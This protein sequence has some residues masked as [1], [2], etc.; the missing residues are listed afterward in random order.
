MEVRAQR[1]ARH[2]L[3]DPRH[4]G[5]GVGAHARRR[6]VA[7]EQL[8]ERRYNHAVQLFLQ[9]RGEVVRELPDG[10]RRGPAHA[11]ARAEPILGILIWPL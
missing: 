5:K 1:G 11:R 7:D 6:D 10:M 2:V 4:R 9:H 8:N 3:H